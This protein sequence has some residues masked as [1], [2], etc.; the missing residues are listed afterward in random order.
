MDFVDSGAGLTTPCLRDMAGRLTPSVGQLQLIIGLLHVA[1][2]H[3]TN[4]G[5]MEKL[6]VQ[7]EPCVVDA[8]LVLRLP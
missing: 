3:F 4:A 8:L 2:D 5:W 1:V 7:G 6:V